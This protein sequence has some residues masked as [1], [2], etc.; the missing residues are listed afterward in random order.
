MKI[1]S[2]EYENYIDLNNKLRAK[3]FGLI[4]IIDSIGAY[5]C[6]LFLKYQLSVVKKYSDENN[7][8]EFRLITNLEKT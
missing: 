4:F 2:D 5:L 6:T 7:N 1:N 8:F 3:V